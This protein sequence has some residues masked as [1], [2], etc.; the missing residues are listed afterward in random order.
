MSEYIELQ[1]RKVLWLLTTENNSLLTPSLN[2]KKRSSG[3]LI[4]HRTSVI[5]FQSN[6]G[7]AKLSIEM[8]DHFITSLC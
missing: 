5:K 8:Q 1:G 2:G 7:D 6:L 4:P 3:V